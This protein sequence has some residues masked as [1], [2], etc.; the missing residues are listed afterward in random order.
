M[1]F[2]AVDDLEP[3]LAKVLLRGRG[4]QVELAD[5]ARRETVEELPDDLPSDAEAAVIGMHGDRADQRDELVRL[6]T[7]AGDDRIA[8]ARD[9]EG[10]PM[11][12]DAGRRKVVVD[13]EL[14][15]GGQIARRP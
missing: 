2:V 7:A 11:L 6:G 8:L 3:A 10:L 15:D 13:Q 1:D 9:D 14:P 5:A 12:V 4:Q